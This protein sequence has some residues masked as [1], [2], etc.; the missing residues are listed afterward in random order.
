MTDTPTPANMPTTA[1]TTP[2]DD[3]GYVELPERT[4]AEIKSLRSEAARYRTRLREA[5]AEL[6][7]LK[8]D[9][10]SFRSKQALD[11]V[12]DLLDDP[13]DLG[14]HLDLTTLVDDTGTADPDKYRAAAE[15]LVA[16][17]PRLAPAPTPPPSSGTAPEATATAT[18][19]TPDADPGQIMSS[20]MRGDV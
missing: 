8:Q 2:V 16:D 3:S 5:E 13:E 18:W 10:S 19:H 20:L 7:S 15:Q 9:L 6:D 17:R 12:A 1:P 11:S 14:R 4:R